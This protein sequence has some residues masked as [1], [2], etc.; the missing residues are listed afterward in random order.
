M[1]GP[2]ACLYSATRRALYHVFVSP[3]ATVPNGLA[4]DMNR[5][6]VVSQH[7]QQRHIQRSARRPPFSPSRGFGPRGPSR[8]RDNEAEEQDEDED[9]GRGGVDRRYTLKQDIDRL[10]RDRMPQDEEITDPFIMVIDKGAPEG[11]LRTQFV[12]SKLTADE[13]LRMLQP[14]VPAKYGPDPDAYALCKIYNRREEYQRQQE[15]KAARR[16]LAA[17]PAWISNEGGTSEGVVASA[18]VAG[19]RGKGKTKELDVSW[20]IG[21]HDLAIKM[22]Q[23][24]RFVQRGMRVELTVERKRGG[25]PTTE[26]EAAALL[27]S[28]R[29][30]VE[31]NGG[32]LKGEPSGEPLRTVK[33]IIESKTA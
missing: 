14:Y 15:V 11:P 13:T 20:A 33:M 30:H 31:A 8:G 7:T 18:V 4:R 27:R 12:L 22:R 17:R 6:V 9:D 21:P 23:M 16:K 2:P 10:R 19:V 26:E 1:K 29:E 3:L 28:I 32:K 25:R 5:R 24:G